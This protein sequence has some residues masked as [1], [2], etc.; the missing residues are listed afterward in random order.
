MHPAWSP[1]LSLR[2]TVGILRRLSG[3]QLWTA[4]LDKSRAT[5]LTPWDRLLGNPSLSPG[6]ELTSC[7][8]F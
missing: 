1:T 7:L 4:L 6:L 3:Q 8:A 2:N 5:F